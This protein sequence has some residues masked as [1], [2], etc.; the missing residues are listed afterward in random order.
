MLPN[1]VAVLAPWRK[2]GLSLPTCSDVQRIQKKTDRLYVTAIP[3][4]RRKPRPPTVQ[5]MINS[6]AKD[7]RLVDESLGHIRLRTKFGVANPAW[8]IDLFNGARRITGRMAK[9]FPQR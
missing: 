9:T 2:G 8:G 3:Q 4:N 7:V 5:R 6:T 1:P